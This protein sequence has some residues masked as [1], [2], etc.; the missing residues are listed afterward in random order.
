MTCYESI[1]SPYTGGA[2]EFGPYRLLP[3]GTKFIERDYGNPPLTSDFA[4]VTDQPRIRSW[5]T[6]VAPP[7]GVLERTL[8]GRSLR[9][10]PLQILATWD[11]RG[12]PVDVITTAYP[13][14]LL[15]IDVYLHFPDSR[16]SVTAETIG[17]RFAIVDQPSAGP[18]PNVGYIA[19]WL[20]G[21]EVAFR[22]AEHDHKVLRSLA[23]TVAARRK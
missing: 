5:R 7:E 20:D 21:F 23:E 3:P 4:D 10:E 17:G 6:Y 1:P 9:G 12:K 22:S 14:Q 13:S 19:I 16:I 18:A 8:A 2:K 15:P 11:V